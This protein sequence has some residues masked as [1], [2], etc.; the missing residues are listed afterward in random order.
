[1]V[2]LVLCFFLLFCLLD[3]V[4]QECENN[5]ADSAKCKSCEAGQF[6]I[7]GTEMKC[8]ECPKGY[9]GAAQMYKCS[10][11]PRGKW[12]DTEKAT[13]VDDCKNCL[14][15]KYNDK[16]AMTKPEDCVNCHKGRYSLLEGMD[17]KLKCKNCEPGY[18]SPES[19]ARSKEC[20]GCPSGFFMARRASF[21]ECTNWWVVFAFF[22]FVKR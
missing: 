3:V 10:L 12:L 4:A 6:S 1:M 15:G 5:C 19:R 20:L 11:C 8:K 7:G 17:H 14:P 2:L 9:Y 13:T 21:V 22:F 16:R 18:Y